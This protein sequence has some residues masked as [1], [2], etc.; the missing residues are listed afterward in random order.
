MARKPKDPTAPKKLKTP[1]TKIPKAKPEK[2][3]GKFKTL[4]SDAKSLEDRMIKKAASL[5]A[6]RQAKTAT[7]QRGP[8][9]RI[10]PTF[11]E[12]RSP[13]TQPKTQVGSGGNGG[14]PPST[15][16]SSAVGEPK[17]KGLARR[18][19]PRM[20]KAVSGTTI[21]DVQKV[22]SGPKGSAAAPIGAGRIAARAIPY[23][24][25]ALTA[26]SILDAATEKRPS[27]PGQMGRGKPKAKAKESQAPVAAAPAGRRNKPI[28][29]AAKAAA[30]A[31]AAKASSAASK[32]APAER[33]GS[34][35]F[36][37]K[38]SSSSGF[39][40]A[41]AKARADNLAGRGGDTF[42]FGG[43]SFST[44]TKEDFKST[45]AKNLNQHL[46]MLKKRKSRKESTPSVVTKLR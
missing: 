9:P 40:A 28:K 34:K 44:A 24:G 23:V 21:R 5:R 12:S 33:K 8:K 13:A 15:R 14:K 42:S 4:T 20:E 32:T 22:L 11:T 41:F 27:H 39:S 17:G 10:E 7:K 45:G 30:G 3:V 43:K 38:K 46:N 18:G 36:A 26:Y 1:S 2:G 16:V 25:A 29:K 35:Q 37:S 31:P 19:S 6:A